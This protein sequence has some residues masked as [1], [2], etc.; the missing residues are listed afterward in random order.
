MI[1]AGRSFQ[2]SRVLRAVGEAA[3]E[4]GEVVAALMHAADVLSIASTSQTTLCV[5]PQQQPLAQFALEYVRTALEGEGLLPPSLV[6][7]GSVPLRLKAEEGK[8]EEVELLLLDSQGEVGRKLKRAFCEPG[9]VDF[10]PPLTLAEELILPF[11]EGGEL[12]VS[13]KPENGGDLRFSDAAELRSVF[14]SGALHPGDLKPSVRDAIDAILERMRKLVAEEKELK[15]AEKELA[16][17]LKR[18]KK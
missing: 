10:C 1:N 8:V 7:V 12:V 3:S 17:A 9:N 16:K 6:C 5:T 15:E 4:A 18:K 2:L 14:A 11:S 13:R